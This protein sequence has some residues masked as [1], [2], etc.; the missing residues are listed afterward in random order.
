MPSGVYLIQDNGQL[1]EMTQQPPPNEDH[2]QR[3]V[4]DYPNLLAGDQINP[5]V[6]RRWL[7]IAREVPLASEPDGGPRWSVDHLF[8]DQDAIPT[9]V[10]VKRASDTRIRREVVGQLLEY[11][12][13]AVTYWP[14]ETIRHYFETGCRER[15][16][17]PD[18]ELSGFLAGGDPEAFWVQ[19]RTN[20]QAGRL[21]LIFV[22]D[23]IPPELRR[24]VE[25][26]NQQM[27]PTEVLAVEV[28]Q[29]G[30]E[31]KQRI[32]TPL[33]IGNLEKTT[34]AKADVKQWDEASFFPEL[35]A[36][37]GPQA[38]ATARAL[39]H[40]ATSR[41]L[42][43]WWGKGPRS[44]SFFPMLDLPKG[45]AYTFGVWTYQS[46]ELQFQH[47]A[48]PPFNDQAH[49]EELRR[50]LNEIPGVNISAERVT[51]RP[52]IKLQTLGAR[53]ALDQFLAVFD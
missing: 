50:R 42:R 14:I 6:P 47:M 30:G 11:A 2:L 41:G 43:I 15:D 44:G 34:T 25:Y 38:V 3:L 31:G 26:L 1:V 12:A 17:D 4:A 22:A 46:V 45:T 29:Y 48:V 7:L 51:K 19:V 36:R 10:E 32:L 20:L 23:A 37:H 39:L 53:T 18:Q 5:T 24:I 33:V 27:A 16:L 49:R 13:N 52:S 35:E 9:L 40:W 21:R 28:R 8:L